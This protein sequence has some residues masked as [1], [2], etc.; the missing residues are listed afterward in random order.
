MQKKKKSHLKELEAGTRTFDDFLSDGLIEYLDV[1]EE[2]DGKKLIFLQLYRLVRSICLFFFRFFFLKQWKTTRKQ[3][4]KKKPWLPCVSM[5]SWTRPLM[6]R[7]IQWRFLVS[8][9]D[10]FRFLI[11]TNL[12]EIR[13]RLACGKPC[14]FIVTSL[15]LCVSGF[16]CL[17]L[18]LFFFFAKCTRA[19]LTQNLKKKRVQW[20]SSPWAL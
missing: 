4:P 19:R 14:R 15:V 16:F 6:W 20:A 18:F 11:T 7:L 8:L 9:L 5:I 3:Q 17:I 1:N 2:N 13:I 12:R 10:W